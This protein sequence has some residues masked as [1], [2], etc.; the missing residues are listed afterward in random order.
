MA[1]ASER[2]TQE[3]DRRDD[4]G[5][6]RSSTKN[7]IHSKSPKYRK[8][9]QKDET[10]NH[11]DSECP[12]LAQNQY[13]KRH[14]TAARAV[15]WSL[16]K[17]YQMPCSNKWYE[18]QPQPVSEI[19]NAKLLWDYGIRTDRVIPAHRPDLTLV[20]KTIN[21][22]SLIDIAVPWDSGAEQKEQEKRDKY[23]DLRIELR[24]LWEIVPLIVGALG[25]IPKSLK[26]NLE[27]L[28]ADVAPGLLQKSVVLDTEEGW[29]PRE[30]GRS[31]ENPHNKVPACNSCDEAQKKIIIIVKTIIKILIITT[32]AIIIKKK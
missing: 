26:R 10:I 22:V 6:E 28:G 32:T 20:D 18:H 31:L 4:N 19:E 17:K 12:A 13:K 23:Q 5:C 25:T 7:K 3:R 9:N 8:C 1:I 11:I 2:G 15:H 16:C 30:A 29:T 21:E 14:D 27:E 24:R